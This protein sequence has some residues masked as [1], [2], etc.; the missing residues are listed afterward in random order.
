[1]SIM[2]NSYIFLIVLFLSF[3]A[4]SQTVSLTCISSDGKYT[5]GLDFDEQNKSVVFNNNK[6]FGSIDL[7]SIDFT[8]TMR[9]SGKKYFHTLSRS[10]G[11]MTVTRSDNGEFVDNLR[12]SRRNNKF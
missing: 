11:I 3:N 7:H 5:L 4:N 10:S 8:I 6:T 9:D 1:M 2:K 12:C